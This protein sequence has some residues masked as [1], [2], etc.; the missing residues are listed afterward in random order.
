MRA[1]FLFGIFGNTK[2]KV[3]KRIRIKPTNV[4][5]QCSFPPQKKKKFFI[6]KVEH[7]SCKTNLPMLKVTIQ[8][9]TFL[10]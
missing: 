4:S 5:R 1:L 7:L 2:V 10:R 3:K 9:F 8:V 6:L